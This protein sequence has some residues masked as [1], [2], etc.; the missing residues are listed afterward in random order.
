MNS[1]FETIDNDSQLFSLIKYEPP[2]DIT[3]KLEAY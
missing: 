1:K 2:I 3:Q